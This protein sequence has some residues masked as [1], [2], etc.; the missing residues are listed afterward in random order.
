MGR[1]INIAYVRR[2]AKKVISRKSV[3]KS[4]MTAWVII[5]Y[6]MLYHETLTK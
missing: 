3:E 1:V 4:T 5:G 6:R 2:R